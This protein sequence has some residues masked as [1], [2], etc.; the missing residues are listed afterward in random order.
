MSVGNNHIPIPMQYDLQ[1]IP[2][3][4]LDEYWVPI[5]YISY[6]LYTL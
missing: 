1:A 4:H 6:L 2:V 5:L 3:S